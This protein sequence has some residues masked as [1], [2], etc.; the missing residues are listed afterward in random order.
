MVSRGDGGSRPLDTH[1]GQS[2]APRNPIQLFLAQPFG[3]SLLAVGL[4]LWTGSLWAAVGVHGGFHVGNYIAVAVMPEVHAVSSWLAI[5]AVQAVIG[6]VLT[7]S[8]LRRERV[9]V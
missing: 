7:V 2:S 6:V 3:F 1:T 4:L 8:A 9:I 5:G